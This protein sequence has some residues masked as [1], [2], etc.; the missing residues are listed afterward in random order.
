MA[1]TFDGTNDQIA[2]GSGAEIDA[3]SAFTAVALVRITAAVTSERQILTKM[4]SPDY[5]GK[6][7]IAA[8]GGSGSDNKIL[9]V[10][11]RGPGSDAVSISAAD[12]L[13][14]NQ[15]QVI[16]TT[17]DGT[18]AI[19]IYACALGG[20]LAEVSYS[21]QTAGSGSLVDDSSATLRV[22]TRDPLDATFFAG[23]VAECSLW[24]RVLSA[25]ELGAL[26]RGFAP[27]F[28]PRGRVFYCPIDGRHSPEQNWSGTTDGTVTEA[29]YL[30]HPRVIYPKNFSLPYKGGVVA[31]VTN[32][33]RGICRSLGRSLGRSA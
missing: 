24:S 7:Y 1:R 14:V 15:W 25:D 27:A 29:V 11:S 12:V 2:F 10:V 13:V 18:N 32:A 33:A 9:A 21:S 6:M 20:A 26:G 8:L 3:L 22:G 17:F 31:A 28:F 4:R 23:G 30:E 16:V 19:K 5:Q